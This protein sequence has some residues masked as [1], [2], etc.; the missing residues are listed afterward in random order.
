MDL[1]KV[2][3]QISARKFLELPVRLYQ[4]DP[5]W[6]RP[7]DQDIAKIFDPQDNPYFQHGECQ[8]WILRDNHEHIIGRV[9]AFVDYQQ[10]DQEEVPTGGM[11]FFECI[12]DH[13]AAFALFDCCREWL[14]HR[15]MQAMDGPI[16]FGD[17]N[18]WWGLLVD[19]FSE[20]NYCMPYNFPYYRPLFESY[21]FQDYF[22]QY[23]Y[24]RHIK[25]GQLDSKLRAKAQRIFKRSG[26]HFCHANKRKLDKYARDFLAVYNQAWQ[27][28]EGVSKMT[29]EQVRALM[30]QL[31][32]VMDERLLWFGYYKDKPIAFFLM[33]PELNQ[34]FRHLNGRLNWVGKLKF[35]YHKITGKNKKVSGL[36]FGVTPRFQGRGV[37]SALI[38]AFVKMARQSGFPYEE[39]ELSWIG[40]FNP[41]MMHLLE[42][43]GARICKTHLTYRYLFDRNKPFKRASQLS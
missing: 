1:I 4:N 23:T 34:I 6:I 11:G 43:I 27:D 5:H 13:A 21:G 3:Q 2:D 20:P 37:E 24:Y 36:V 17:R 12:N 33:V 40:D 22:Q 8:R 31:K 9:A 7:L 30:H 28:H 18:Q 15:G 32:P 10:A 35:L 42:Q 38:V 41:R 25:N 26:Y 14:A 39:L 29:L 19:G 16:N